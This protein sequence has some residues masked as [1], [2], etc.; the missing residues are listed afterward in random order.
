MKE[1]GKDE[2]LQTLQHFQRDKI[3][4]LD[5]IRVELILGYYEFIKQDLRR[6]VETTRNTG[7]MVGF[8]NT[9]FIALIPKHDNLPCFENFQPISLC[10]CL[11][12][13]IPKVILARRLKHISSK[14]ISG[15]QFR[16]LEGKS[17]RKLGQHRKSFIQSR[18]KIR[19]RW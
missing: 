12:K 9:T 3:Q 15:E 10:D 8:Y 14:K 18:Q 11:Y 16:F 6:M 4:R 17:M 13:I 5:G 2:L 1:V 19:N 7:R